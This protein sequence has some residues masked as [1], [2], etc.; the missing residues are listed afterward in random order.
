MFFANAQ[1]VPNSAKERRCG[2]AIGA[3][4]PASGKIDRYPA[5]FVALELLPSGLLATDLDRIADLCVRQRGGGNLRLDDSE[6]MK[7]GRIAF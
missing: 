4:S 1:S 6:E 2:L 3:T 5:R 7:S